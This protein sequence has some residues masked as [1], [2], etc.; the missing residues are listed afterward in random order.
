MKSILISLLVLGSLSA[1]AKTEE[2][3]DATVK[4]LMISEY[5]K[6]AYSSNQDG[7]FQLG[8]LFSNAASLSDYLLKNVPAWKIQDEKIRRDILTQAYG[9]KLNSSAS[10]CQDAQH[11]LSRLSQTA[12]SLAST[13][14][15]VQ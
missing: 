4:A 6:G 9:M 2:Q 8:Q 5:T 11:A 15:S 7:C 13:L 1:V 14:N 12:D 3:I 10:S